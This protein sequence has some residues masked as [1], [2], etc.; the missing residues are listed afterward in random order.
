ML[1]EWDGKELENRSS[2]SLLCNKLGSQP[3]NLF[4][5]PSDF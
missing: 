5:H 4:A 3:V 1:L 2:V